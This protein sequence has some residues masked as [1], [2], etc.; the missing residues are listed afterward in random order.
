MLRWWLNHQYRL[1]GSYFLHRKCHAQTVQFKLIKQK[2]KKKKTPPEQMEQSEATKTPVGRNQIWL[3]CCRLAPVA[4]WCNKHFPLHPKPQ[5]L[6][7][8]TSSFR[9]RSSSDWDAG[10]IIQSSECL[11]Q[12]HE[13]HLSRVF[14]PWRGCWGGG[15]G[16]SLPVKHSSINTHSAINFS[17]SVLIYPKVALGCFVMSNVLWR[18]AFHNLYWPP[19]SGFHPID[20]K[21]HTFVK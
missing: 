2:P 15:G 18:W 11:E 16:R 20:K 4:G 8:S 6:Y 3:R 7:I 14:S 5:P 17:L 1:P 13:H 10:F 19:L 9:Q 21:I 12:H